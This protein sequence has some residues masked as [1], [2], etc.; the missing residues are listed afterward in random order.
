[1]GNLLKK[2]CELKSACKIL[3][4]FGRLL[5][6]SATLKAKSWGSVLAYSEQLQR[7]RSAES[8]ARTVGLCGLWNCPMNCNICHTKKELCKGLLSVH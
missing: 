5:I 8:K 6:G 2:K 3:I 1:M 4:F 7:W